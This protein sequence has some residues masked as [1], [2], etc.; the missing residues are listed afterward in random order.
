MFS[1]LITF[2]VTIEVA[3]YKFQDVRI[4]ADSPSEAR[5]LIAQEHG[6]DVRITAITWRNDQ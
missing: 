5:S 2:T 3:P 6:D 1:A 4:S